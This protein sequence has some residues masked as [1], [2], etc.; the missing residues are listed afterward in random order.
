[1]NSINVFFFLCLGSHN[2]KGNLKLH[3]AA[4]LYGVADAALHTSSTAAAE[5]MKS[6][7]SY[8]HSVKLALKKYYLPRQLSTQTPLENHPT[9]ESSNYTIS[10]TSCA[11]KGLS[12]LG[13]SKKTAITPISP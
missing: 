11:A 9:D 7:N 13:L 8:C 5:S 3:L 1:M 10:F 12:P 4:K 6:G 2:L